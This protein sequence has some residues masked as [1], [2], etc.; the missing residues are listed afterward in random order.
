[1]FLRGIRVLRKFDIFGEY[2]DVQDVV[3]LKLDECKM[4]GKQVDAFL[5]ITG[6]SMHYEDDNMVFEPRR[7]TQSIQLLK[8]TT[9]PQTV[10]EKQRIDRENKT[11]FS[12][13]RIRKVIYNP[14]ATI[15]YW[16]DDTKTVVKC[17]NGEM[18]IS[19]IGLSM[20]FL[21]KLFGDNYHDIFKAHSW[22]PKDNEFNYYILPGNFSRLYRDKMYYCAGDWIDISHEDREALLKILFEGD[23]NTRKKRFQAKAVK[24]WRKNKRHAK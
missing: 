11:H 18:F 24:I 22:K 3:S 6:Y 2:F 15:V 19:E 20:C 9:D 1:M 16:S 10:Y 4:A 12:I 13:P 21:K 14:P 23:V 5:K 7:S 8:R 17:A